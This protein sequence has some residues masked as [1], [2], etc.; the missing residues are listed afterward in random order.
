[1]KS[2]NKLVF[3]KYY[4]C[5]RVAIDFGTGKAQECSKYIDHNS[6]LLVLPRV[7]MNDRWYYDEY[8]ERITFRDDKWYWSM[9]PRIE[10]DQQPLISMAN[11]AREHAIKH[12]DNV[13]E[14]YWLKAMYK[15]EEVYK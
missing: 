4:E 2:K 11:L 8:V 12:D 1:M 6:L 13:H 9:E 5:P 14:Y 15:V 10:C 3:L 7:K